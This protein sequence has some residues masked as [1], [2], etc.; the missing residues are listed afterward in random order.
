MGIADDA[1]EIRARGWRTLA[2]LHGRLET[3]LEKAL[4]AECGLSVV[5]YTVLDALS[6][7]DGWHMRMQQLARATALSSS[8]TTRLV[9]RL[10]DRE[11]LT[12]VL[13]KDDRRGIYTELTDS[14]RKLLEKARPTHDE[15]LEKSLAEAC[16]TPELAPLVTALHQLPG[17]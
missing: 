3:A 6:R 2:A 9:S 17:S 7:Q 15:V 1:V 8:A 13:C 5:E 12:R 14:G 16:E 11:L 4:Q 10:E